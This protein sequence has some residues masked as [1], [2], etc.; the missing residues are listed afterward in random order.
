MHSIIASPISSNSSYE[1]NNSYPRFDQTTY[2]TL[3]G[4]IIQFLIS[5]P[6]LQFPIKWHAHRSAL[7]TTADYE[8]LKRIIKYIKCTRD[9]GLTFHRAHTDENNMPFQIISCTDASYG[10]H[11]DSKSQTGS[12]FFM[13]SN[14]G[15]FCAISHKQTTV[16]DS[17]CEAENDACCSTTKEIIWMRGV[18]QELGG[19]YEQ[20][21]PNEIASD[22]QPNI[23]ISGD[24]SGNHKRTKHF[25]HKVSFLID[26]I[27]T[28]VIRLQYLP[29]EDMP[30]NMLTKQVSGTEL[31]K[32]MPKILGMSPQQNNKRSRYTT[33][34][35]DTDH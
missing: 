32:F 13:G 10:I 12:L 17:S 21:E 2:M 23:T 11:H 24:Y 14:N 29:T 16:A 5:R 4:K 28:G 3:L 26:N 19:R 6:D 30:A 8:G 31:A 34:P 27:K 9:Y 20:K 22:S 15:A 1:H 25:M 18:M 7:C 33:M 35:Q